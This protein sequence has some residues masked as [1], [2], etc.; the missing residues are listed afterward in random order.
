MF[1]IM[2]VRLFYIRLTGGML[3]LGR[4]LLTQ[5]GLWLFSLAVMLRI[6]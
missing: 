4:F 3:G 6:Y 2:L 1:L 5:V